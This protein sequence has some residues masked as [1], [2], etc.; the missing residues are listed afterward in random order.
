MVDSV[1]SHVLS[2]AYIFSIGYIKTFLD[3]G[4]LG[5]TST[6]CFGAVLN[7]NTTNKK[8]ETAKRKRR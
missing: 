6:L 4:T 7:S 1:M 8:H 3:L 2:N 5:S